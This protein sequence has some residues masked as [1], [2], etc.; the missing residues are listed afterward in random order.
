MYSCTLE[1]LAVMHHVECVS[2]VGL[3]RHAACSWSTYRAR[4]KK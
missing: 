3:N 4:R 2:G 1:S